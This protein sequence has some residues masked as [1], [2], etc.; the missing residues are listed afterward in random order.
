MRQPRNCILLSFT[1]LLSA[2]ATVTSTTL[3]APDASLLSTPLAPTQGIADSH[4]KDCAYLMRDLSVDWSL[5]HYWCGSSGA[6]N[7]SQGRENKLMLASI[8]RTRLRLAVLRERIDIVT[9]RTDFV[10]T[11]ITPHLARQTATEKSAI[12]SHETQKQPRSNDRVMAAP[13]D[14]NRSADRA[15]RIVF[16]QGRERLGPKGRLQSLNLIPDIRHARQVTLRGHLANGEFPLIDD[17]AAERRSVGRSLSVRELWRASGIDVAAV[18]ILHY[19]SVPGDSGKYVE[20]M[21][22]E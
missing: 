4:A 18:T 17:L 10:A 9:R 8:E 5:R 6:V 19:P 16:A 11:K 7:H 3:E 12:V 13:I 15:Y 1:L 22:H 2:C 14:E 21:I 20:V